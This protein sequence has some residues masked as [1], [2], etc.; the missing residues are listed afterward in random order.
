MPSLFNSILVQ[1]S[2]YTDMLYKE[3]LHIIE[4]ITVI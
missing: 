3:Q 2:K 1:L 4:Y